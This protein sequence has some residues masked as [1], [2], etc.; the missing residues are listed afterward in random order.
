MDH[1]QH[2][3]GEP[4]GWPSSD[5]RFEH[6]GAQPPG[7]APATT[8][9]ASPPYMLGRLAPHLPQWRAITEDRFVLSVITKGYSLE[10]TQEGPPA[11]CRRPN[12]PSCAEHAEFV[13][14]AIRE[15]L[16]MGV[17]SPAPEAA[18]HCIMPLGVV[19]N[20]VKKRL[21]FNCRRL[22]KHLAAKKFKFESLGKEGRTVFSGASHGWS[23]DLKSAFYHIEINTDFRKYLGIEWQGVFYHFNALPF[24]LA[25]APYALTRLMKAVTKYWR[26][27]HG[28]SFI[29]MMDDTCGASGSAKQARTHV[30]FVISHLERL[31]FVIQ[32][33]KTHGDTEP[34]PRLLALGSV[35]D[36]ESGK[37]RTSEKR[38]EAIFSAIKPIVALNRPRVTARAIARVTGL[39]QASMISLGPDVRVRTRE[40]YRVQNSRLCTPEDD[41][42]DKKLWDRVVTVTPEALEELRWW[43]KH[44][45]RIDGRAIA[46]VHPDIPVDGL[47]GTDAG[48]SGYGGWLKA[49]PAGNS[50]RLIRNLLERAPPGFTLVAATR[51]GM[52][53]LEFTGVF[54]PELVKGS[55]TLREMYAARQLVGVF[56]C[57]LEGLSIQLQFDNQGCVQILG[58]T[59]PRFADSVFGG[60]RKPEIHRLAIALLDD[61]QS[62]GACMVP[63]WVPRELNTRADWLSHAK[64]LGFWGQYDYRLYRPTFLFLERELGPHSIDRFASAESTQL[65][66]FNS[67]WFDVGNEWVDCFSVPWAGENNYAFP[68]PA[69]V[70]Q[71]LVHME[72]HKARGTL[73]VLDWGGSVF[74]P[75]L[76]PKGTKHGPAPFVQSIIP[77]GAAHTLLAYPSSVADSA[78]EMA[79]HLP[80]G[81]LL[82]LQINFENC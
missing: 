82:A 36:F 12:Q 23:L 4:Q 68:P 53:G 3:E 19:D 75:K 56:R 35:V 71:V 8:S 32:H 61:L 22:N 48:A 62:V 30:R 74:W 40:N 77:L 63:K 49:P 39:L 42:R 18:L 73:V 81:N 51:Q 11:R 79:R 69:L 9:S 64:E 70:P 47:M 10:F 14:G 52:E 44:L 38:K 5:E 46:T 76:F 29:Q 27:H 67:Q 31:G 43:A 58:G 37:F 7:K 28:L 78:E 6:L 24:G 1:D 57:L 55:S 41:P 65:A 50:A 45:E 33:S 25:T 54:P 60:S 2:E 80:T 59:I 72:K 16:E 66:R 34:V 17:I 13:S 15:A 26:T 20:G 21:I